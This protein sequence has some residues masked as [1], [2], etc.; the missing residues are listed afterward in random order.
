[1]LL[2]SFVIAHSLQLS[3]TAFGLLFENFQAI[4]YECVFEWDETMMGRAC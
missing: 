4:C 1:M 3:G 2:S